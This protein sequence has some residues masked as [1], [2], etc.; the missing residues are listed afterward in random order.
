MASG[1]TFRLEAVLRLRR[2]E[3]DA[4]RRAVAEA[5]RQV[6]ALQDCIAHLHEAARANVEGIRSSQLPGVELN[7]P[8]VR[9]HY[10]HQAHLARETVSAELMLAGKQKDLSSRRESLKEASARAK[11][12]EKLYERQKERFERAQ[13]SKERKVEDEQAQRLSYGVKKTAGV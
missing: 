7:V 9:L 8:Q 3:R 6:L 4:C 13:R 12:I 11:A 10:T 2:N 5:T 1:F